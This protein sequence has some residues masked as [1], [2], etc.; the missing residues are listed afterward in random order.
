M[1][2][3]LYQIATNVC[4]TALQDRQRRP[5][6]S[7]L[8]GPGDDPFAPQ[9]VVAGPEVSW[10]QPIPD[11][12]VSPE[13]DDPATIVAFRSSLRL[14]LIASL[15][16]L[17][18]RQRAVLILR[19][20]LV[21]PA[22]EVAELLGASVPAVKSTLQ[23]ARA[24]LEEVAPSADQVTEPTEPVARAARRVHGSL[25]ARRCGSPRGPAA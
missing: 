19:D 20:V 10:L 12:L 17:P 14:A 6:P 2:T 11:A 21:W 4:L 1:R 16:Y 13:T 3:W 24:R 18:G 9:A 8:G 25:R 7:D 22:A 23:L 15:Q 5:L